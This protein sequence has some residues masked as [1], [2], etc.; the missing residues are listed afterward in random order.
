MPVFDST[1]RAK[2]AALRVRMTAGEQIE[3]YQYLSVEWPSPDGTANYGVLPVH[4]VAS[5]APSVTVEERIIPESTPDWFLPIKIDSSIGDEDISVDMWDADDVISQLIEDHGEGIKVT[6]YDFYPQE[7]LELPVWQGHLRLGEEET[8]EMIK[9]KIVQGLRDADGLLPRRAHYQYCSAPFGGLFATVADVLALTDCPYNLQAPG[10]TVG[11]VN[12]ATGLPWTYCDRRDHQSCIDR[13]VD[14]K[15]HLSHFT[16]ITTL[17]NNQT[18]GPNLLSNSK[19]NE[20]NLKEPVRVVM[21]TRRIYG[22]PVMAFSGDGIR[23]TRTGWFARDL[24]GRRGPDRSYLGCTRHGR[25]QRAG[26]RRDALQLSPRHTR[27]VGG[28][29]LADDARLQRDVAHSL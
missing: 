9:L 4:E 12:P 2:I 19:G 26:R 13:G 23:T 7:T 1:T 3:V 21:G 15:F 8:V 6:A 17:Q 24:R 14:P 5:V 20:S 10:G 16:Q 25:R 28:A 27:P 11:I 22:M 18:H 29:E